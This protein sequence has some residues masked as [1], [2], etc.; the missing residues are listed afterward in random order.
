MDNQFDRSAEDL[1]NCIRLEHLNTTVPDQSPATLF[2][3]AGLGLTRDP[4]MQAGLD[5]MWVN[6]GRSQFHLPLRA[7]QVVRGH[8]G[9]VLPDRAALLA[10][11]ATVK[12]R[13]RNTQFSWTEHADFVEAVCP[14]GNHIRCYQPDFARFGRILLGM[15]YVEFNV[16]QGA[17]AGIARFYQEVMHMPAAVA[18]EQPGRVASVAAGPRQALRFRETAEPL[19]EYDGHHVAI[20]I[21]NFSGPYRWLKDKGLI[22]R[23]SDPY[24]YRF[25][26]IY[27]LDSGDK[28][29]TLEHEVRSVTHPLF[30][31]HLVNRDPGM[32]NRNYAPGHDEAAWG[33][34][35]E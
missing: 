29:Y 16:P 17:A 23:E 18:D 21:S 7:P 35:R 24:E 9:L 3:M 30:T 26:D 12:D 10:R 6:C 22:T 1:G 27:D 25:Q 28:V 15:P 2:Y 32:N 4:F 14:W 34:G 19:P 33:P 31:R 13:L 5:N 11:L 8:T 20:Y